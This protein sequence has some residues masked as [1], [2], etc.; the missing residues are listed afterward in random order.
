MFTITWFSYIALLRSS[1]Q[2]ACVVCGKLM[3][4]VVSVCHS[5]RGR[6]GVWQLPIMPS[7][8]HRSYGG[9]PTCSSL[10][11]W[12]PLPPRDLFKLIHLRYLPAPAPPN[13]YWQAGGWHS[14]E[15]PSWKW[16]YYSM[17]DGNNQMFSV[18]GFICLKVCAPCANSYSAYFLKV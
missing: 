1:L 10:F 6:V 3:F 5:G 14:N 11:T 15:R 18:L 13:I 2:S 7:L 9:P 12:R 17:N 16:I 4:S 8:G